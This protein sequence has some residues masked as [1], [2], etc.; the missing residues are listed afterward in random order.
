MSLPLLEYAPSS[1]NQRVAGFEV[2]GDEQPRIYTIRNVISVSEI[3]ALIAATY[4]QVFNEQQMISST[5]QLALE[6]QLKSGQITVKEFIRGLLT[7]EVFRERN[8]DTNSNYRFVQMCVQR[9]LGREVYSDREKLAWST[10]LA[11]KGLNGFVDDLLNSEEYLSNFG[12]NTVPY[13]RRR[14]L[15][16]R[17]RGDLPFARMARYDEHYRDTQARGS[18]ANP[19]NTPFM[20]LNWDDLLRNANIPV[21][22]GLLIASTGII[23]FLL[24]LTTF[25]NSAGV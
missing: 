25:A 16:Q 18:A 19:W 6:S 5:R 10:V 2:P 11:T 9:L 22:S 20:R 24:L 21:I 15:P 14:V 3:E 12:E 23:V 13:Q 8:Y 7:S 1:Q 4:R 17:D